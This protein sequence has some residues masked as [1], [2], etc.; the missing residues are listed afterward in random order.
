MFIKHTQLGP[1]QK[2]LRC[3]RP[4]WQHP[5]SETI[6]RGTAIRQ[7]PTLK[8]KVGRPARRTETCMRAV[9][10]LIRACG[11]NPTSSGSTL[12]DKGEEENE[13][14]ENEEEEGDEAGQ[15]S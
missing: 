9:P 4:T 5:P 13:E 11:C 7:D 12:Q 3:L 15:N 1:K 8:K 14:E 10:E 2:C 6:P